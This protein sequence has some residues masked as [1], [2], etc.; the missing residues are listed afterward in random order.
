M[1]VT[2]RKDGNWENR[3]KFLARERVCAVKHTSGCLRQS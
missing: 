1:R 3:L 2:L